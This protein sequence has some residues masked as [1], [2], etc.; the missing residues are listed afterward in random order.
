MFTHCTL[1]SVQKR[2][3]KRILSPSKGT[4]SPV[5]NHQGSCL[6]TH[7]HT[8]THKPSVLC[9]TTRGPAY[10]HTQSSVL[11]AVHA[12]THHHPHP[13]TTHKSCVQPPGVL[14]THTHNH[15]SCLQCTHAHTHITFLHLH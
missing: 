14:P 3:Q 9:A 11:P 15:Q 6:H 8:H 2:K 5:C 12:H 1:R 13:H 7:T 10:T 4:C